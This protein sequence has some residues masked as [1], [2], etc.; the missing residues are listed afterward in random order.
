MMVYLYEKLKRHS[1]PSWFM[2]DETRPDY[3]NTYVYQ[4]DV[5]FPASLLNSANRC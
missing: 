5:F 4:D 1:Q 3:F 2:F